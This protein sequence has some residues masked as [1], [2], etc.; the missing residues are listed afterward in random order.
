MAAK[1][2]IERVY[3]LTPM[4]RG[5]LYTYLKDRNTS[6]YFI[7]KSIV[8][9]GVL[10][11]DYV[12]ASLR[13]L[14]KK[15]S[16]LRTSIFH[17]VK[18]EPKQVVL[19]NREIECIEVQAIK[20]QVVLIE[21][22]DKE[23]GFDLMN[24]VLLR[25]TIA[26]IS[27][28][29]NVL[30]WSFHH[31]ILDGWCMA[32][33]LNDFFSY[34]HALEQGTSEESLIKANRQ[35]FDYGEYIDWL[36]VQDF[37]AAK[38]YW[39]KLLCDYSQDSRIRSTIVLTKE[40]KGCGEEVQVLSQEIREKTEE[41]SK[42]L[43]VTFSSVIE[44]AWGL[45]LA[46]QNHLPEIVYGKVVSGRNANLRNIEKAVGLFI[47]TI[48]VRLN[49]GAEQFCDELIRELQSQS[50]D[51]ERFD[52]YPLYEIAKVSEAGAELIHSLYIFENYYVD[53]LERANTE[54]LDIEIDNKQEETEYDLSLTVIKNEQYE[55]HINYNKELLSVEEAKLAMAHFVQMLTDIVN[56]P[57]KKVQDV[58]MISGEEEQKLIRISY[59]EQRE[60]EFESIIERLEEQIDQCGERIALRCEDQKLTY[61]E[62]GTKVNAVAASMAEHG[63]TAGDRVLVLCE[64]SIEMIIGIYAA[65]KCSCSY[66]P[67]ETGI[68][69]GRIDYIVKDSKAKLVLTDAAVEGMKLPCINV[70]DVPVG[71][72]SDN[73]IQNK[74]HENLYILYTSGTTGT[75]KGVEIKEQAVINLVNYLNRTIYNGY[76]HT[77]VA[78]IA[79]PMFDAS[80]QQIFTALLYGHTLHLI[81]DCIKQNTGSMWEYLNHN[82]IMIVDGTPSYIELLFHSNEGQVETREYIIGGEALKPELIDAIASK[83]TV[84]NV[85]NVYGPTETTVDVTC[86]LCKSVDAKKNSV[87]IG[88]PIDNTGIL[89]MNGNSLCGIGM[90]GEICIAGMGLFS[91]YLNNDTLTR[92]KLRYVPRVNQPLFLSGDLGYWNQDG[93]IE[94]I[95]RNDSQ[96]K[97]HG[98]RIEIEEIEQ[99]LLMV[100]E[101]QKASVVC[102]EQNLVTF[103]KAAKPVSIEHCMDMLMKKLPYYMIPSRIIQIDEM[104]MTLSGKT[105]LKKLEELAVKYGNESEHSE[106]KA[107]NEEEELL[108]SVYQKILNVEHVSIDDNFYSLGGDSIQ[109]IRIISQLNDYDIKIND[110]L[111]YPQIRRLAKVLKNKK[112]NILQEEVSGEMMLLP[113]YK[114]FLN[115]AE[116]TS[117]NHFNQSMLIKSEQSVNKRAL[118]EALAEVVKVHDCLR[119]RYR[120]GDEKAEILPFAKV[121]VDIEEVVCREEERNQVATKYQQSIKLEEGLAIRVVVLKT[122]VSEYILIILH[123]F[124]SDAVSMKIIFDDLFLAYQHAKEGAAIEL[125]KK[126]YSIVDW[127]KRLQEVVENH[128][129]EDEV[130]FWKEQLSALPK[131]EGSKALQSTALRLKQQNELCRVG[132]AKYY[133]VRIHK[134]L[135]TQLREKLNCLPDYSLQDV[136]LTCYS[137]AQMKAEKTKDMTVFMESHGRDDKLVGLNVAHT[138]GWFTAVYPLHIKFDKNHKAIQD[139]MS[140]IRGNIDRVP[141]NGIGYSILST[142]TNKVGPANTQA[143]TMFNY[144]GEFSN[145]SNEELGLHWEPISIGKEVSDQIQMQNRILVNIAIWEGE[146]YCNFRY[147]SEQITEW[148]LRLIVYF[149]KGNLKKVANLDANE[150]LKNGIFGYLNQPNQDYVTVINK[151]GRKNVFLFPPAML[152]VAYLPVYEK[153]FAPYEELK[154]HIFHLTATQGMSRQY[155]DYIMEQQT[156]GPYLFIGYSGG[157]NI[158]Y[159][160]ALYLQNE[161]GIHVDCIVML[162]G[163]K[164]QTGLDFVTLTEENIDGMLRDFLESS[165]MSEELLQ[166]PQVQH[167]LQMER[168]NFLKEAETYQGYCDKHKN[169]FEKLKKAAVYNLLSED[170]FEETEKDTRH[171]WDQC[172]EHD[173]QYIEVRGSHLSM[174]NGRESL[175][176]NREIIYKLVKETLMNKKDKNN[177]NYV[178][179]EKEILIKA[180]NVKKA[181]GKDEA[182]VQALAGVNLEVYQ[183]EF[184]VILGTSGSG[185]STLLNVLSTLETP[186]E[187]N[188]SYYNESIN[189]K[190]RKQVLHVRKNHIGFIFQQYHLIPNL[191]VRDNVEVGNYLAENKTDI[192]EILKVIGL[193][194]KMSKYP[195][196]LSGGE[197]QRVSIARALAKQTNI[198]FCDEPTGAL[199]T[200]TGIKVLKL[201]QEIQKERG[202]TIV[203]VTHNNLIAN[204]AD[205]VVYMRDGN[206]TKI[207]ENE[208]RM[209][210]EEV[211]WV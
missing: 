172:I 29:E 99:L 45:F 88:V 138:V 89:I 198:L 142:M 57:H 149:F 208:T 151:T 38:E 201:L 137:M 204:I 62:L 154:L 4:Q 22:Q 188:V 58:T 121:Q 95:G 83:T 73:V 114:Q 163:F 9:H 177:K 11:L 7:Q 17:K 157:A 35:I 10:H 2:N 126:T 28:S 159:D 49:T 14:G 98:Y 133:E 145:D 123:H 104:P 78:L 132:D 146:L 87:S 175:K 59:G 42:S 184:V 205:R 171:G 118:C 125:P 167:M 5:M 203:I 169:R 56:S 179:K 51:S 200:N 122:E 197:Q 144:L 158:A 30:I 181:F 140:Y 187:G 52:Y 152:K 8:V 160:T 32:I 103:V 37:Q 170:V 80:V 43:G 92:E 63:V 150:L 194:N 166:S 109:A 91:G 130:D 111:R 3:G 124:A 165:H 173:V 193:E 161:K 105:D 50:L 210:V 164:W 15:H 207:E 129:L 134:A 108:V 72:M 36:N 23:Y 182:K 156:Q 68:P 13:I 100:E 6:L 112:S 135:T 34:Y 110:I 143:A 90:I 41:L 24:D 69:S 76:E 136:L 21:Q 40:N 189:Y 20:E 54:G 186:D 25:V 147:D 67:V 16:V 192:E 33:L 97:I 107:T 131:I 74:K 60:L 128:L 19:V 106:A 26:H 71:A 39:S 148:K 190:S 195:S 120:Y 209:S 191:T 127:G 75:P 176:Y 31:I 141:N 185:K 18:G 139:H 202:V 101:I 94:I 178:S 86:Y 84:A 93:M 81:T 168:A 174:L 70:K 119:I 12:K 66:I 211:E 117:Y 183:G 44:F 96:I 153:L 102:V 77:D 48:P 46:K 162:D 206:I 55:F 85:Y 196:Q 53:K 65:I 61:T 82:H 47:N 199:D 27:D 1:N 116:E 79:S 115:S 180:E 64:K 113:V 155:A